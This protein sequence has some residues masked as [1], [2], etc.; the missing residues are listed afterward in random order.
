MLK[1]HTFEMQKVINSHNEMVRIWEKL[2]GIQFES[3]QRE[4]YTRFRYYGLAGSG[5]IIIV[6]WY[7]Y[8]KHGEIR[9]QITPCTVLG[10]QKDATLFNVSEEDFLQCLWRVEQILN[11]FYLS[12]CYCRMSRVDFTQDVRFERSEIIDTVIRLLI[13]T[14]VPRYYHNKVYGDKIYNNSYNIEAQEGDEVVVYNKEKQCADRGNNQN[15]R[16]KGVM[17][18]EIRINISKRSQQIFMGNKLYFSQL[19]EV[20][21][22]AEFKIKYVFQEG[23]YVKLRKVKE[24]LNKELK[25]GGGSKRQRNRLEKMIRFAEGVAVHQSLSKC[26][27]GKTAL[28]CYETT[29]DILN[30][31][32]ER[33]INLVSIS[34][35]E[36]IAVIPDM[37]YILGMKSEFEM[38]RDNEFLV[39]HHLQD[40]MPVY[41]LL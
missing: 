36:P 1:I 26:T 34:A 33:R 4:S 13:R 24:I 15:A 32:K 25:G 23:F 29:Q 18:V 22:Y 21:E 31:L 19:L 40:K 16:M 6:F 28:F 27:G 11:K 30:Q 37:L 41:E 10:I 2:K 7:R 17:R 35:K 12:L 14:G 5:V 39:E 8:K 9:L 38:R 3:I 20:R